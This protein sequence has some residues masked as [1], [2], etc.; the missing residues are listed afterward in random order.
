MPM[1]DIGSQNLQLREEL[2]SMFFALLRST[3]RPT[4]GKGLSTIKA[5]HCGYVL[6]ILGRR[7]GFVPS[8]GVTMGL[9]DAALLNKE[10]VIVV[11][12]D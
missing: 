5:T 7:V 4:V 2:L 10:D 9:D 1:I 6:V 11:I 12:C 3:N 8:A